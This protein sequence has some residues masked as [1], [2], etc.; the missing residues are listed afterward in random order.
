MPKIRYFQVYVSFA[1]NFDVH[2]TAPQI[3]RRE[4][5]K[6]ATIRAKFNNLSGK[7]FV[8]CPHSISTFCRNCHF[9]A[10]YF[11]TQETRSHASFQSRTRDREDH[12]DLQRVA[13][14]THTSGL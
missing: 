2:L 10:A 7:I 12:G 6:T 11:C 13:R 3:D 1:F 8:V 14:A 5:K 4:R 9:A